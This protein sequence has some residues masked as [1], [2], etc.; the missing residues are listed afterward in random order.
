MEKLFK[1]QLPEGIGKQPVLGISWTE[2]NPRRRKWH[3][4]IFIQKNTYQ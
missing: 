3:H 1:T 2:V 4:G